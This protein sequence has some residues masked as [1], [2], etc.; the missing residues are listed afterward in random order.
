MSGKG[1]GVRGEERRGVAWF[2]PLYQP[3]FT[4]CSSLLLPLMDRSEIRGPE[5]R[6]STERKREI[7]LFTNEIF[8]VHSGG[9]RKG[10]TEIPRERRGRKTQR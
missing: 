1:E 10:R 6:V 4:P 2:F 8:A 9:E 7:H 3:L 5:W